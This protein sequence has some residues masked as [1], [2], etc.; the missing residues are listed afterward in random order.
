VS[1]KFQLRLAANHFNGKC[2][3]VMLMN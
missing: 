1:I 2:N 3:I